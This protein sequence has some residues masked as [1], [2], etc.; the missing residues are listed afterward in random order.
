[1]V[2][3]TSLDRFFCGQESKTLRPRNA[4]DIQVCTIWKVICLD[5]YNDLLYEKF[6]CQFAICDLSWS[7]VSV[8]WVI[9]IFK[10]WILT[11]H[12]HWHNLHHF[13]CQNLIC[14]CTLTIFLIYFH[15]GLICTHFQRGNQVLDRVDLIF[16]LANYWVQAGDKVRFWFWF[17]WIHNTK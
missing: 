4:G 13:L 2:I 1:M 8:V 9:T 10:S 15:Q 11:N 16:I 7:M 17:K 3:T 5:Q 14:F 12:F 6:I